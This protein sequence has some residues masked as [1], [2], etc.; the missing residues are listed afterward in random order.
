[1]TPSPFH[2]YL[3]ARQLAG[4][5]DGDDR[6]L[7][8]FASADIK[9]FPYQIAAAM[10]ALRSPYLK[11]VILADEGSLGKTYEALLVASQKWYE[12]KVRQL[13]IL[14]GNLVNQWL[15]KLERDFTLP[16]AVWNSSDTLPE[17][18]ERLIITTYDFVVRHADA[19]ASRAWDLVIFDEADALFK[20]ENKTVAT[21]KAATAGA[22][23]LLLTP[24]PITMSIMDIY[25]LIHFI[26]ES[27][28]PDA[29]SF[30]KRYFRK[31]ENYPEL[32]AWVSQFAFR[33]L[34]S[35]VAEY[36]NFTQRI[37]YIPSIELL[38]P[39]RELY[40]KVQQFIDLPRKTSFPKMEQWELSLMLYHSLSSS[41]QAFCKTIEGA[42]QRAEGSEKELLDEIRAQAESITLTGKMQ[43]LGMVLKKSKPSKA[44]VFTDNLTTLCVLRNFLAYNGYNV[45]TTEQPDYAVRFRVEKSAILIATDTAA[46]GLDL[47]FCP[48]VINYDLLWNAIEMEQRIAR[49]H[50]QGQQ[51]DVLVV[52]LLCKEN[53][54][55]VRILELINKRTLQ[56]DGIFGMSDP[57]VG[58]FD[59]PIESVL[60]Q[61]RD[62][63]EIAAAFTENL[64]AHKEE[65]QERVTNAEDMLFTTFTKSVADRV[66]VTPQYIEDKVAELNDRLWEVV[67]AYFTEIKEYE[68]DN[69]TRTITLKPSAT[70]PL[71]FYYNTG[72]RN[73][74]YTGRRQYG[75]GKEFKPGDRI[76]L[77]S[78]LARGI[79]QETAG[80]DRGTVTLAIPVEPCE[81]GFYEIKI[82][83]N[84]K[85]IAIFDE[86]VGRTETGHELTDSECREI[87]AMPVAGWEQEGKITSAWL[88]GATGGRVSHPLDG[89][90]PLEVLKERTCKDGAQAEEI[91]RIK[92]RAARKK[93]ALEHGLDDLQRE[94]KAA[95]DVLAA[96]DDRRGQL[97]ADKRLK[98]LQRD[99]RQAQAGLA[100]ERARLDEEMEHEVQALVAGQ[101]M[102]AQVMR[103]FVV[104]V[105]G[106]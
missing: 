20:P 22:F 51:S 92:L 83:A 101:N 56:F 74:P 35:Q 31:P 5:M 103:H 19:I 87:M 27:V 73:K 8:A 63:K 2:I 24:T 40:H 97:Q 106:E 88:R 54:A 78:P 44:I 16:F 18:E 48:M 42:L 81:I 104:K 13:V 61:I 79:L 67:S 94:V 43:T 4:N 7:A 41:P 86:F 71:L 52:N 34:K 91:E 75:M 72:N 25:G 69:E 29:D 64:T 70:P 59:V 11:G 3:K 28:L 96:A 55:D 80:A 84:H 1:M 82:A 53:V 23:K 57:I 38:L 50:R 17:D 85:E 39:E 66:T 9:I 30:Y 49:C 36:V 58:N 45:I 14:P 77:T 12:G 47:E 21:L 62:P 32:T 89:L 60:N 102:T 98:L 33:T 95:A 37:T 65:N 68:I 93:S 105:I 99:L 46:K 15:E 100:A 26:D 6:L 90:V 10:F 76:T